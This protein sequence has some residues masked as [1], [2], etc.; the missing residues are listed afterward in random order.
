MA[1]NMPPPSQQGTAGRAWT[2]NYAAYRDSRGV[3][4]EDDASIGFWIVE[5]AWAHPVWHSYA[6]ILVH[7]RPLPDNRKT[8]LYR[9]DATHELW[10][11][12][13]N[14]DKPRAPAVLGEQLAHFLTPMNFA[15]QIAEASDT[16]ARTRIEGAIDLIVAGE[17]NPDTDA[18]RQWEALFGDAMIR[19]EWRVHR[20]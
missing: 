12:A 10:I 17:L 9:P 3:S 6:L 16:S 1:E 7:L 8:I 4:P 18:Q 19:P 20:G 15:A 5:A 13:L 11:Y 14:P 2:C